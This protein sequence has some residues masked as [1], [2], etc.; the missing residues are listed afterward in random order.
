MTPT[1]KQISD[2]SREVEDKAITKRR[3]KRS[4]D[5]MDAVNLAYAPFH[6]IYPGDMDIISITKQSNWNMDAL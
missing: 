4:P 2:G 6:Q 5:G 1:W 3:L